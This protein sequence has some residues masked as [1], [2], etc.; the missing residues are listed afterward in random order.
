MAEKTLTLLELMEAERI[1]EKKML[2]FPDIHA[3]I[4][5]EPDLDVCGLVLFIPLKKEFAERELERI[6]V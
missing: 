3:L 4:C 6:R 2:S 1:D 5:D